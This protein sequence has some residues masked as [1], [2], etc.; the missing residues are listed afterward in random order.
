MLV[1]VSIAK[2]LRNLNPRFAPPIEGL[3][4]LST[5]MF[6]ISSPSVDLLF[7]AACCLPDP[8]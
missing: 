2:I 5:L 7:E 1:L 4:T 8:H 3:Y 6:P